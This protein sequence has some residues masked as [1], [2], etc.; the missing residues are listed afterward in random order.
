MMNDNS[1][2]TYLDEIGKLPLLT[3]TESIELWKKIKQGDQE[4][5]KRMVEGNMRLV[6]KIAQGYTNNNIPLIDL[7][8]EGA[9]GLQ[10]AA[11]KFDPSLGF[12]FSTYAAYWIKHQITKTITND[13][14]LI[15]LPSNVVNDITKLNKLKREFSIVNNREPTFDEML[16]MTDMDADKL[17][18]VLSVQQGILS[19][20][21][22]IPDEDNELTLLDLTPDLNAVDPADYNRQQE[23]KDT[24]LEVLSTLDDREKD[25]LIKRFGLDNGVQK[26]LEQVG[27]LVGLT[28]ERV[29]QLEIGALNKLRN[30]VRANKLL[31]YIK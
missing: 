19:L 1:L 3:D 20:D 10:L 11:T 24:I 27:D 21:Q 6:V 26:S 30:P 2:D 28:R 18:D 25:I 17:K 13:S 8:Q 12:K 7:I 31:E 22:V 29:R 4:A 9:I 23:K 16:Q 14:R 5:L 15:R